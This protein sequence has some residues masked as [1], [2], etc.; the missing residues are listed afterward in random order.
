[1]STITPDYVSNILNVF[2]GIDLADVAEGAEWYMEAR[3]LCQDLAAETG[4]SVD[5]CAGVLAATSPMMSWEKNKDLATRVLRAGGL[6]SG[7][8][9]A[10][11]RKC[12]A[13]LAG[14]DI[15]AT[16]NGLKIVNFWE[17]IRSGGESGVCV[18]RHAIDIAYGKRHADAERPSLTP[19]QYATIADAYVAAAAALQSEGLTITPAEVQSATWV[20]WRAQYGG[21]RA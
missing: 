5:Q 16:L 8:L 14:A 3:Q 20:A 6:S 19:K 18:D 17:S 10:G 7:Y 12:D 21:T 13:I 1:M 2:H 4:Y 11:L 15:R 9:G